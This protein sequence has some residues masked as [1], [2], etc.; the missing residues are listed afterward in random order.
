MSLLLR[1]EARLS[2]R[3]FVSL[4]VGALLASG[5]KDPSPTTGTLVISING[6]PSATNASVRI[7]GPNSS[8]Q[9]LQVTTT[10]DNLEPGD[11]VIRTDTI[12]VLGTRY[13]ADSA[14][15]VDTIAVAR[16]RTESKAVSYQLASGSLTF[17]INGLPAGAAANL[18]LIGPLPSATSV[19]VTSAGTVNMLRPGQYAV[20]ADTMLSSEGDRFAAAK[21]RDT[22]QIAASLAPAQAVVDY[23][24]ISGTLALAINGIPS[25][26]TNPRVRVTGPGG[27]EYRALNSVTL[28]GLSAGTYTIAATSFAGSCPNTYAATPSQLTKDVTVGAT[29]QASVTYVEGPADLNLRI[30]SVHLTQTTQ[31][32]AGTVPMLRGRDAYLRVFGEANKCNTSQPNVRVTVSGAAQPFVIAASE[33]SVRTSP[34]QGALASSWNVL[35]PGSLVQLGMTVVAE[36]DHDNGVAEGDESDNRFPATGERTI[37]VAVAPIVGLR[38]VPVTQSANSLTG[39]INAANVDAFMEWSRKLHPVGTY[40]V[41]IRG[42]YTTS[43][44]LTSSGSAGWGTVLNEINSLRV[45]DQSNRYYYGV[46]RVSYSRGIAGIAFV[47]SSSNPGRAGLGW[48]ATGGGSPGSFVIAHEL[49]HNFGRRH[50][51]CGNPSSIDPGYPTTGAYAG[52]RIGAYGFDVSTLTL[53]SPDVFT[54]VMGYCTNQWISDYTY[55][56]MLNYLLNLTS[57]AM[58]ASSAEQPSLLVWGRIENGQPVLE[59]AFEISARPELPAR[60][61][62][63][64]V[65]ALDEAGAELFS[66][67]FAGQRIADLPGEHESFVFA[68]PLSALRGR[69]LASLR[70]DARGKTA[71]SVVSSDVGAQRGPRTVGRVA[72]PGCHGARSGARAR[73]VVRARRRRDHRDRRG[74]VGAELLQ[75]RAQH[76]PSHARPE[77]MSSCTERSERAPS[78]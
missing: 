37:E 3:P 31:N 42:P 66:L 45:S 19:N 77:M 11:Y 58:D 44:T 64:R 6:L 8:H 48:D 24:Q 10:L 69:T 15:V 35:I 12:L 28:R 61:G 14:A 22:V 5:C 4:L 26:V 40:D 23:A 75:P 21:I 39:N 59:P 71:R 36:I 52:G 38:L 70:L 62:P 33:Q 57:L 78:G 74:R 20:Q 30:D 73:A 7:T 1:T 2:Q 32:Y 47:S 50:S 16:G 63:H 17:I 54:D 9:R 68:V 25:S 27:F 34:D 76:A 67:S 43:T 72:I 56:G 55:V 65:T 18:R 46:V 60:P 41:D 49:G 13:G 29:T 53:K 51:H